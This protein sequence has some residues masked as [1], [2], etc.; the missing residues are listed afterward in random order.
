MDTLTQMRERRAKIADLL[1][2]IP[3]D[4][5]GIVDDVTMI[6]KGL[7]IWDAVLALQIS[8]ATKEAK[9]VHDL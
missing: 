7:Q 3:K 4:D 8:Q 1:E 5:L 6:R 9:H 2:R